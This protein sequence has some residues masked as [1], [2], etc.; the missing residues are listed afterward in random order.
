MTSLTECIHRLCLFVGLVLCASVGQT[1]TYS[2]LLH[3]VSEDGIWS[4]LNGDEVRRIGPLAEGVTM[5]ASA[6]A[7][8]PS[9]HQ[10]FVWINTIIDKFGAATDIQR[11]ATVFPSTGVA[12]MNSSPFQ[13]ELGAL[14]FSPAGVL[15]GL[16]DGLWQIDVGSGKAEEIASFNGE[17][18]IHGADFHAD[19]G[20]LYAVMDAN[21]LVTVDPASGHVKV[22]ARLS[23]DVGKV[24]SSAFIPES[25]TLIGSASRN[26]IGIRFFIDIT[27]GQVSDLVTLSNKRA[28]QGLGYVLDLGVCV[29][30]AETRPR[31]QEINWWAP[32][33]GE[34]TAGALEANWGSFGRRTGLEADSGEKLELECVAGSYYG[35]HYKSSSQNQRVLVGK[36]PFEAGSNTAFFTTAGDS[37]RNGKPDC[38]LGTRWLSKDYGS[39][40]IPNP[41]TGEKQETPATLDWAEWIFTREFPSI[42]RGTVKR[43][44]HKFVY[45][46]GPPV[47]SYPPESPEGDMVGKPTEIGAR[48]SGHRDIGG[49]I[50]SRIM[51]LSEGSAPMEGSR[52]EPCDFDN[53]GVC[54]KHDL[55]RLQ[56]AMGACREHAGYHPMFDIDG[57]GCVT[58]A[59]QETLFSQ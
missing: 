36:C 52:F 22:M 23:I 27:N 41:W 44:G 39:N 49:G 43:I 33:G 45:K 14:A 48:G 30:P 24:G 7:V 2:P 10:V 53:S 26:S 20:V 17:F 18:S 6:M 50:S 47:S 54:D 58:R 57:D 19:T 5:V 38:F 31:P 59:D 42:G 15:Y 9:D 12:L 25:D 51:A 56:G 55:Q 13:A 32:C 28:Q 29:V 4:V 46:I 34:G 21:D 35:L 16:L 3:G 40:D 37:N 11:L 8:R 1:A